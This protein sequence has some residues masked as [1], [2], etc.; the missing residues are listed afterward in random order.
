MK[1]RTFIAFLLSIWLITGC[2]QPAPTTQ[3]SASTD[4]PV[5]NTDTPPDATE[6]EPTVPPEPTDTPDPLSAEG[7]IDVT[8][9]TADGV[10]LAGTLYGP[11]DDLILVMV[12]QYP[13]EEAGWQTFAEAAAT[14]G[15]RGLTFDLRGY[16]ASGGE[17]S[18][19]QIPTDINAALS[20]VREQVGAQEIVL[21]GASQGATGALSVAANDANNILGLAIL[22]PPRS[23]DGLAVTD[24][25]LASIT[26]PSRWYAARN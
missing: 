23:V 22:S 11:P 18:A 13:G 20:F 24:D 1:T 6:P 4:V 12:P 10:E 17:R 8:F 15:Y 3:P 25:E 26:L 21:L 7:P 19:E 2:S 5:D 14:E 16:G 9:Q